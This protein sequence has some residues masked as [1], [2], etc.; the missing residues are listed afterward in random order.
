MSTSSSEKVILI[1]IDNRPVTYLFPQ[2]VSAAAGVEAIVPSREL[3]GS[4]TAP[5][6]L[7]VL[8]QWLKTSL[9]EV[10]PTAIFVC[11]DSLLYGGLI[12]SRR[13]NDSLETV[14]ERAKTIADWKKLAGNNL[15][16]F[17]QASVMRIPN[18]NDASE[19]PD[20]WEKY[21]RQLFQWSVL[22]HKQQDKRGS[23]DSEIAELERDI[24]LSIRGD[25]SS[26]RQRNFQVNEHLVDLAKAG[27]IDYLVFSQDDTGEYGLN[28]LE[29]AELIARANA[30]HTTNITAYAGADEVLAVLLARWLAHSQ[31][32][33]LCASV[34][35]SPEYGKNI[36]SNFEGQT[37]EKSLLAQCAAAALEIVK[38]ASANLED[39]TIIVHTAGDIQGDHQW[40]PGHS[41]LRVIDTESSVRNT[42]K[43]LE[44]V[45]TPVILCDVAYS[46]GADPQ[47][48]KAL[49]PNKNLVEKVWSYAGW[50]TTGNT[51]GSALSLGIA[52]VCAQRRGYSS[53]N[54]CARARFVRFADD[55]AYQTQVRPKLAGQAS[56]Q[57]LD[58]LM[59]PLIEQLKRDLSFNPGR[60]TLR[61]P[62]QRTFEVEIGLEQL[63]LAKV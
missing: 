36:A 43:L 62:W 46:N 17:A 54:A 49:L 22:R 50:N 26:R 15:Q 10:K 59:V 56:E 41:D 37:I 5:T 40:L 33:K 61:F 2:M 23:V 13:S 30:A 25:F 9:V 42:L 19:E 52:R 24:P 14:M 7:N 21:G 60:I 44:Q 11:L 39:L 45:K 28:V 27:L 4:L 38:G 51:I 53:D 3:M 58:Q 34:H 6:D 16:V 55:W 47:L 29:K 18:Y 8:Q 20:Y 31:P 12:P 57:K 63:P 32:A 48:I 35:F 1:P